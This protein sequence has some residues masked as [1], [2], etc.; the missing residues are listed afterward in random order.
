MLATE[1]KAKNNTQHNQLTSQEHIDLN[2]TA[3]NMCEHDSCDELICTYKKHDNV[4][5]ENILLYCIVTRHT[6]SCF[7]PIHGFKHSLV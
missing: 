5:P 4:P 1:N 6:R 2:K 7:E 3:K